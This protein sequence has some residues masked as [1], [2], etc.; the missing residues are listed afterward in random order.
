[1]RNIIWGLGIGD[2]GLGIG[3]WAQSPIPNPQSPIPNPQ[4]VFY[5]N[6]NYLD[7]IIKI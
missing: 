7:N 2:W 4:F 5:F 6:Y 1:M 3:D